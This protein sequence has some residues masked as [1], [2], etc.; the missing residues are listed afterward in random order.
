MVA[1]GDS[2]HF[3]EQRRF[4]YLN[5][6]NNKILNFS[7]VISG[8]IMPY[9]ALLP[10]SN[11]VQCYFSF[12]AFSEILKSV[13]SLT[14]CTCIS[15]SCHN[16]ETPP[17]I[18]T[19]YIIKHSCLKLHSPINKCQ[20]SHQ[21]HMGSLIVTLSSWNRVLMRS[22]LQSLNQ[23]NNFSPWDPYSTWKC[24]NY[25]FLDVPYTLNI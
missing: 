11:K 8:N 17:Y 9:M 20:D 21:F 2:S 4:T 10:M 14:Y 22:W 3:T 19:V 6:L 16:S 25:F 18:T 7:I 1:I 5:I 24:H 12:L 15:S 23:C 13:G